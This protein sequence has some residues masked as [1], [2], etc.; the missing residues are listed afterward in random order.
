[1]TL[2]SLSAGCE[3]HILGSVSR[4]QRETRARMT[5]S[6]VAH[7]VQ[8]KKEKT[9]TWVDHRKGKTAVL[10]KKTKKNLWHRRISA[11]KSDWTLKIYEDQ[12]GTFAEHYSD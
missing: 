11:A 9:Q 6:A 5:V 12:A 3:P 2:G 4:M 10:E 7:L 8:K 1:M